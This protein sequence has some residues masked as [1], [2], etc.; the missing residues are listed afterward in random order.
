[1][2][3]AVVVAVVVVGG[4]RPFRRLSYPSQGTGQ[5]VWEVPSAQGATG[6][7]PP[8]RAASRWI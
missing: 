6:Q 2:A 5:Q 4:E 7:P 8:A 1:M 3:A